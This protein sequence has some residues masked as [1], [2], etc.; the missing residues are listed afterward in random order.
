[1]FGSP[2][3]D[4]DLGGQSDCT[5]ASHKRCCHTDTKTGILE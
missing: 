5:N 1:M 2:G 3:F 4:S